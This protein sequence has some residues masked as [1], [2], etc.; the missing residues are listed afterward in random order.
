MGKQKMVEAVYKQDEDKEMNQ[1]SRYK[2]TSQSKDVIIEAKNKS[3]AKLEA[4]V[5][6]LKTEI[7]VL[8]GLL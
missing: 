5:R 4:E 7:E 1:C 2:K 3:I 6:N 8:R